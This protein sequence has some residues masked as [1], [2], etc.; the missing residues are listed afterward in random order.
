MLYLN[1]V[2]WPSDGEFEL[3]GLDNRILKASLLDGGKELAHSSSFDPA[4][5]LTKHTISIPEEAPDPNVS[6]I[7][8]EIEGVPSMEQTHLQQQDGAVHLW[9]YKA[10]IHDQ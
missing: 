8:L 4:A 5:T 3:Y 7:V 10:K 1:V 9:A 2:D 6:V